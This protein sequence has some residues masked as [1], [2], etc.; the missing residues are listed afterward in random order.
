MMVLVFCWRTLSFCDDIG[1]APALTDVQ[2]SQIKGLAEAG[3]SDSEIAL[4]VNGLTPCVVPVLCL[5]L[6]RTPKKLGR[7]PLLSDRQAR[8][9]VRMVATGDYSLAQLKA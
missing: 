4:R 8:L 3:M 9:I 1:P 7:K 2:R 5:P 6:P